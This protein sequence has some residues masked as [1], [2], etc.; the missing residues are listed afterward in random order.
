MATG[1]LTQKRKNFAL[2]YLIDL[3]AK[4]AA[5]R[6]GY[7]PHT[8]K[9]IGY[10]LLQDD[11]IQR[12]IST[13]I[14]KRKNRLDLSAD[15]V[16]EE[17]A[18]VAFGSVTDILDWEGE[19]VSLKSRDQIPHHAL[20]SIAEIRLRPGGDLHLKMHSKIKA[21]DM[22]GRYMD[23]WAGGKKIEVNIIDGKALNEQLFKK[24]QRVV[25]AEK[26]IEATIVDDKLQITEEAS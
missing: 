11:R 16:L 9:E 6:A 12:I 4:D 24:L 7:S 14:E 2:E 22:L 17:M 20:A 25:K 3:C 15:R 21:L 23:L 13:E 18:A 19:E 5:I 10:A 8:A 1:E 26:V